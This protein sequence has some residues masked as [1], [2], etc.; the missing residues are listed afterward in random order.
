MTVHETPYTQYS[1]YN[2]WKEQTAKS[3]GHARAKREA[4]EFRELIEQ[5]AKREAQLTRLRGRIEKLN[6]EILE[7]CPHLVEHHV[8]SSY[9]ISG[10]FDAFQHYQNTLECRRCGKKLEQWVTGDA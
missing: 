3:Q 9:C 5:R 1:T 4:P 7:A 8:V 6:Q 2:G 10:S